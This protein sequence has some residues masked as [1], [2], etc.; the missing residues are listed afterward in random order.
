MPEAGSV[1]GMKHKDTTKKALSVI[2]KDY[3]KNMP[4]EEYE[5]AC[6]IR[7]GRPIKEE[8][9]KKMIIA[10][11][12]RKPISEATRQKMRISQKSINYIHK[13][14][15]K[16]DKLRAAWVLRRIKFPNLSKEVGDKLRGR[17]ASESAVA[18]MKKTWKRKKA[19]GYKCK[20]VSEETKQKISNTLKG[21]KLSNE[22]RA[23][24]KQGMKMGVK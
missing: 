2:V 18:N 5:H 20:P 4:E 10:Q 3:W 8:T 23:N 6:Q 17:K 13:T 22:H 11:A 24:I 7:K 16:S 14:K 19:E 1:R 9:R 21:R 15:E 12:N